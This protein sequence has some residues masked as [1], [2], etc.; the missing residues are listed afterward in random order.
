MQTHGGHTFMHFLCESG[1]TKRLLASGAL[2]FLQTLFKEQIG[3]IRFYRYVSYC[4][5]LIR[6]PQLPESACGSVGSSIAA[7]FK[8]VTFWF[9]L[10]RLIKAFLQN[11][12]CSIQ[13]LAHHRNVLRAFSV[14]LLKVQANAASAALCAECYIQRNPLSGLVILYRN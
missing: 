3:C 5:W 9:C 2:Q 10:T 1:A 11:G 8:K 6:L 4:R 14:L 12:V 7:K 13:Q